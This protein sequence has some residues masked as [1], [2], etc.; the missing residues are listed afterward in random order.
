M[1]VPGPFVKASPLVVGPRGGSTGERFGRLDRF[2]LRGGVVDDVFLAAGRFHLFFLVDLDRLLA[3]SG[4]EDLHELYGVFLLLTVEGRPLV[5][6]H[7]FTLVLGGSLDPW[8]V[9]GVVA[10]VVVVVLAEGSPEP[11]L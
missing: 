7:L 8:P 5:I 1:R 9:L 4:V 3:C 2:S 6:E 10:A 11:V